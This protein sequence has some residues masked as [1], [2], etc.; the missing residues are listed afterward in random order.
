[1]YGLGIRLGFYFQWIT[2]SLANN[3]LPEE[4]ITM[5]GIN[6]AFQLSVLVGLIYL[7][8]TGSSGHSATVFAVEIFIV[9][10]LCLGGVC[11]GRGN[12]NAVDVVIDGE[13]HE[14]AA[15]T[16]YAE[17]RVTAIGRIIQFCL[18]AALQLYALWFVY[19]G[20]DAM[21]HPPCSRWVFFFAK[22]DL[23]GWYRTFLKVMF[24][25]SAVA[26]AI[27]LYRTLRCF[28]AVGHHVG[29]GKSLAMTL[30]FGEERPWW[31]TRENDG[32]TVASRI[33]TLKSMSVS[34][35][36][37]FFVVFTE[38]TIK[39]NHIDGLGRI[40]ST[41]Q[42]LPLVV[43]LSNLVKVLYKVGFKAFRGDYRMRYLSSF[44]SHPL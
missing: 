25:L 24:T 22:V 15:T 40:G 10:I 19:V 30:G 21:A 29:F 18:G 38:M 37:P 8:R 41:G 9:M 3:F 14:S 13:L 44:P 7:T 6:N 35:D 4:A 31:P 34:L 12:G 2:T 16:T 43:G 28:V 26:V 32:A 33:T 39:W 5:R 36:L 17:H 27:I 42:L 11:S 23:Y 20:M 1:M